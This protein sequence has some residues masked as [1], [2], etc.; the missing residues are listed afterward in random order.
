MASDKRERADQ[1]PGWPRGLSKE[2]EL[3]LVVIMETVGVLNREL[4]YSALYFRKIILTAVFRQG[5]LR[6]D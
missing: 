2:L 1:G 3:N 5:F 4:S 6:V